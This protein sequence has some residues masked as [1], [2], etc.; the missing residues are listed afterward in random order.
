MTDRGQQRSTDSDAAASGTHELDAVQ[1]R[2]RADFG[3][4]ACNFFTVNCCG[5]CSCIQANTFNK[6]LFDFGNQFP[7]NVNGNANLVRDRYFYTLIQGFRFV[8]LF[9]H[10]NRVIRAFSSA[11]LARRACCVRAQ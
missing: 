3:V 4:C 9:C 1:R 6:A 5:C 7:V 8:A 2:Q 10:V 11:V